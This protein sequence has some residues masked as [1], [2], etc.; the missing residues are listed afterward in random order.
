MYSMT[1]YGRGSASAE[2]RELSVE[3][4]SVN[5]R[6][7]D[8][9]MR[10]PRHLAFLEDT[11]RTRLAARLSRGHVD[12]FLNYRNTRQDARSVEI[13]AQLLTAYVASARAANAALGLADDLG[14][15]AALRLPDVATLREADED[16]AAVSALLCA[17]LDEAADALVTMRRQEGERLLDDLS[18][19]VSA[20]RSLT[21]QIEARAPLVVTEYRQ[22]LGERIESLLNGV[23]VDRARLATEVALFADRASIDEEIVRL[24]SH[25]A[26]ALL[27]FA[28]DEPVGRKLDFIVQEMNREFNTIGS[29]ANDAALT[30]LVLDGKAEIEKIREQIQN[31]E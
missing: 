28:S 29:K 24:K 31:I 23:E 4:K 10:L 25:A 15:S 21:E 13:D 14:L 9:G 11:I 3:L 18:R 8:I 26:Q 16:P 27:L 1:G 7:L 19:R 6:Y 22:K 20:V 17:A 5:H 30:G 12:V 2:G